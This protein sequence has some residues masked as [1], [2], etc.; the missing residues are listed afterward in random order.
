M[1]VAVGGSSGLIG[2]AL[3][4]ELQAAGHDVIRL[5]RSPAHGPGERHWSPDG[6]AGPGLADCDAVVNL[7]GA[8]IAGRPWTAGYRRQLVTSRISTTSAVVR[9][10]RQAPR[11]QVFLSGSA[12]GWYGLDAGDREL[13]ERDPA[14]RGFLA[15]VCQQWENAAHQAP[16]Q[17]RVVLLRTGHVLSSDGGYL[18][19]MR[20]LARLGLA[21]RMGTGQQYVSWISLVDHVRAMLHLLTSHHRGPVNV[22]GPT[23]CRQ[24]EFARMLTKHA[25]M[26]PGQSAG[27]PFPVRLASIG[28]GREAVA[29]TIVAGQRVLP[30]VLVATGFDFRDD[31][32]TGVLSR[33]LG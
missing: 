15:A 5:V 6:I 1:R 9:A 31:D 16:E 14:G 27:L 22:V 24:A 33:E 32:L 20:P 30:Q 29:E 3:V 25:S 19:K 7:A 26:L 23:P 18:A 17:V 12:I 21:G 13:T 2:S 10:L 28:L 8:P 11:C 4:A